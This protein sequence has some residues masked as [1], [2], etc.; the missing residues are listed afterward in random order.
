MSLA[1]FL[2]KSMIL[3]IEKKT[4]KSEIGRFFVPIHVYEVVDKWK[5]NSF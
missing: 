1:L 2:N 4:H 5:D 3:I